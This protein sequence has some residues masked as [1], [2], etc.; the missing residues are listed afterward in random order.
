MVWYISQKYTFQIYTWYIYT[1]IWITIS[2]KKYVL[3]VLI[4]SGI[5]RACRNRG[6][7]FLRKRT[8]SNTHRLLSHQG[9]NTG[10]SSGGTQ[11]FLFYKICT[12]QWTRHRQDLLMHGLE[13]LYRAFPRNSPLPTTMSAIIITNPAPCLN[14]NARIKTKKSFHISRWK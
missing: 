4:D 10:S 7:S 3:N 1:P 6:M 13:G 9:R 14:T 8:H 11:S 5:L 2:L 12:I